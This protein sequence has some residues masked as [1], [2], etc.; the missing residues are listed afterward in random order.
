MPDGSSQQLLKKLKNKTTA[1]IYYDNFTKG[2]YSTDA[3]I[4]QMMPYGVLIPKKKSDLFCFSSLIQ[5][6]SV[7]VILKTDKSLDINGRLISIIQISMIKTIFFKFFAILVITDRWNL[8]SK[9]ETIKKDRMTCTHLQYYFPSFQLI[10][11]L[12]LY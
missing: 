2:R 7:S 4:Y 6:L 12:V 11:C 5:S 9:L 10:S 3:S 8:F 1:E